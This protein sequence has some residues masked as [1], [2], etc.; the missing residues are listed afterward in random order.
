MCCPA[1]PDTISPSAHPS[2][3]VCVSRY[4]LSL[5]FPSESPAAWLALSCEPT[6][7]TGLR[8]ACLAL[9]TGSI[10]AGCARLLLGTSGPKPRAGAFG[11]PCTHH[12]GVPPP[13]TS[14]ISAATSRVLPPLAVS[15]LAKEPAAPCPAR[16][17]SQHGD[18]NS[19]EC[20]DLGLR[21]RSATAHERSNWSGQER[22]RPSF[23]VVGRVF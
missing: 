11:G 23:R 15:N 12:Q 7:L 18:P 14:R 1:S 9:R 22:L 19:G 5:R 13:W 6:F 2:E 3:E 8:P 17:G 10:L 20:Q 21:P 16:S 4:F